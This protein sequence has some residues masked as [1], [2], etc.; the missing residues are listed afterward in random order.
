MY[1]AYRTYDLDKA[2]VSS[3]TP[4]ISP[5]PVTLVPRLPT[6]QTIGEY[7]NLTPSC[8]TLREEYTPYPTGPGI[9]AASRVMHG[10]Y[11]KP[12]GNAFQAPPHSRSPYATTFSTDMNDTVRGEY[13]RSKYPLDCETPYSCAQ[14][15]S[16]SVASIE[17]YTPQTAAQSRDFTWAHHLWHYLH[18]FPKYYAINASPLTQERTLRYLESLAVTLPCVTCY[19]HYMNF[20]ERNREK[21]RLAVTGR[22]KLFAFFVDLHNDVNRRTNKPIMSLAQARKLYDYKD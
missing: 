3:S 4:I 2:P 21:V 15:A 10:P 20:L 17:Q 6:L 12:Y 1:A 18:T 14:L 11:D 13:A 7:G 22:D 9:T 19:D 8:P 16:P 5:T